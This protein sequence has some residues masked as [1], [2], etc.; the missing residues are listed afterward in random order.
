MKKHM[1]QEAKNYGTSVIEVINKN[2]EE[3]DKSNKSI[4]PWIE[5]VNIPD[6]LYV[7]LKVRW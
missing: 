7:H 2:D 1:Q 4:H 5:E 3:R 6:Y